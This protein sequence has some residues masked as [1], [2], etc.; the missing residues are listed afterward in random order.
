LFS[1][2]SPDV[3]P[4]RAQSQKDLIVVQ[5]QAQTGPSILQLEGVVNTLLKEQENLRNK[6]IDQEK[7]ISDLS[8]PGVSSKNSEKIVSPFI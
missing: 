3:K 1:L 4:H 2:K 6:I 8:R 7:L 5:N